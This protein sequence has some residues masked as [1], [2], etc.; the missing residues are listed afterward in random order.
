M[1]NRYFSPDSIPNTGSLNV[2]SGNNGRL[3]WMGST[4]KLQTCSSVLM[5]EPERKIGCYTYDVSR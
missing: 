4:S 5:S 1:R 3:R 2:S